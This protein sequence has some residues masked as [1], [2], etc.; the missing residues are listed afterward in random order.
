MPTVGRLSQKTYFRDASSAV[1]VIR[2]KKQ[3]PI[4]LHRHEFL[5]IAVVLSGNGTYTTPRQSWE[6]SGGDIMVVNSSR[7]HGYENTRDLELANVLVREDALRSLENEM[8]SLPGYHA[9]FTLERLRRHSSGEGGRLRL[10]A[11]ALRQVESWISAIEH[12]S[13]RI[14]EGGAVLARAWLI[15]LI[16][17]LSRSYGE[18]PGGA[19][20]LDM[21][22][23]RILSA[24]DLQPEDGFRLH[25]MAALA[26]MSERSFL[27]RFK[28]VTSLSPMEYVLR[29][30]VGKA[31]RLME[32]RGSKNSITEIAFACGF[33][34]SNYFSRQFRR[35]AGHSPREHLKKQASY[36]TSGRER[37]MVGH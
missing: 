30:R 27:R 14:D 33:N 3:A 5:E 10:N 21:R 18:Q 32:E 22:M 34:D 36:P 37:I 35:I 28:E 1:V 12:E 4:P 25:S 11:E 20:R 26:A 9:L 17:F 23:G 24:I 2:Q 29:A 16:G 31:I 7:S 6:I 13:S 15:L 19:E 8:G